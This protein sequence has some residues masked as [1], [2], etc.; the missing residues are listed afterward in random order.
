HRSHQEIASTP[1]HGLNLVVVGNKAGYDRYFP[2]DCCCERILKA[3][4]GALTRPGHEI[5]PDSIRDLWN[6]HDTCPFVT[7]KDAGD[8]APPKSKARLPENMRNLEWDCAVT[9]MAPAHLEVPTM[10]DLETALGAPPP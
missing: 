4:A 1:P 6:T 3:V 7:P 8:D 2:A 10:T 9:P 5:T